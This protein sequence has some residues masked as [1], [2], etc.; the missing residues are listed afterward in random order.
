M[1]SDFQRLLMIV[2][3]F[4]SC[5]DFTIFQKKNLNDKKK[6]KSPP[7]RNKIYLPNNVGAPVFPLKFVQQ[8]GMPFLRRI[9]DGAGEV[10]DPTD[11]R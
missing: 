9:E 11:V 3:F 5:P 1:Y 7:N 10:L 2:L 8:L 6:K 4:N